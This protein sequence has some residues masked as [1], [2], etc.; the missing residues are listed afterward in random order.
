MSAMSLALHQ[1]PP[2]EDLFL[3]NMEEHYWILRILGYPPL[4]G[5]GQS[6]GEHTDYGCVVLLLADETKGA[7]HV[8]RRDGKWFDAD[9][10]N[11]AY[12]VNIGDMME[13][14]TNGLWK[15]TRHRVIHKGSGCRVSVPFFLEPDWYSR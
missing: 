13:G 9:P 11:G 7:L 2:R 5:N 1:S 8:Q 4:E 12:V 15:S 10:M 14:W 3:P 6:C